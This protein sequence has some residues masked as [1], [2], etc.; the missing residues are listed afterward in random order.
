MDIYIYQGHY[1][2][3]AGGKNTRAML[4]TTAP[5]NPDDEH[6][7]DSDDYP[8]GP[9]SNGGGKADFPKHCDSCGRFLENPLTPFGVKYVKEAH[10]D[11]PTAITEEW[12]KFY[13]IEL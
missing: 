5:T 1:L 13:D 10:S 2:C 4:H 12:V 9:Y 7:F 11:N 6:S 8:K 3:A